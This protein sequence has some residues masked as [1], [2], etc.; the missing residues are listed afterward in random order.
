MD[1]EEA[2]ELGEQGGAGVVV[3]GLLGQQRWG[4]L[5]GFGGDQAEPRSGNLRGG[6]V[7]GGNTVSGVDWVTEGI[8]DED[9]STSH[10]QILRPGCPN[11]W[12]FE[13]ASRCDGGVTERRRL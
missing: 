7:L 10:P 12:A 13:V 1:W 2:D 8:G 4:S 11:Q 9:P 6:L 5:W 3:G